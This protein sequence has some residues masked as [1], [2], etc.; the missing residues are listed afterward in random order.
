[1][2]RDKTSDLSELNSHVTSGV[3]ERWQLVQ[4]RRL[5]EQ[6]DVLYRLKE[7]RLHMFPLSS[8]V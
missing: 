7:V 2:L 5:D 1:M 8:I 3:Q 4:Q 6:E